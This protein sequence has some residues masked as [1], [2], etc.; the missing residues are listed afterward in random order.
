AVNILSLTYAQIYFPTYSNGLKDIARHLGFE[1]SESEASGLNTIIW[2]SA[3]ERTQNPNFKRKL[4]TYNAEDCEAAQR[5]A[6]AVAGLCSEQASAPT[7]ALSVNVST[8]ERD[9]PLRFGALQY[10][11]PDF[12][13]INEAAYWNYQRSKVYVRSSARLRR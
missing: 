10:V 13:A 7:E 3:W 12:K 11:T 2:R 5:V 6:E 9:R 8:L 4:I 1:W